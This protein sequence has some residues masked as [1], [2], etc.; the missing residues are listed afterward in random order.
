MPRTVPSKVPFVGDLLNSANQMFAVLTETWLAGHKQAEINIEG[1]TAFRQDR[2]CQRT[3]K[4]GRDGGGALIY[5]REDL[6]STADYILEFSNGVVDVV[7]IHVKAENLVIFAVYRQPDGGNGGHR[8]RPA[9]LQQ[10]IGAIGEV[11]GNLPG[12]TPDVVLAGDFNLP[13]MNWRDGTIRVG[14]SKDEQSMIKCLTEFTTEHFLFQTINKA[15]HRQGNVLDL[16]F[17]NNPA[18]VHSFQC[19]KTTMSDHLIIEVKSS[20]QSAQPTEPAT[21]PEK[22]PPHSA[23]SKFEKLNFFSDE[24]NWNDLEKNLQEVPWETELSNLPPIKMFE[25]FIDICATSSQ[26]FCPEKKSAKSGSKNKIPRYRRNLMRRRGKVNKQLAASPSENKR[27]KLLLENREIELKLQESYKNERS[28]AE[29]HAV[30]SIKKNSKY[31]YSYAKKYSKVFTGIGPLFDAANNI[32]SCANKMSEM[33]S[34]QYRSVFSTP[35]EPLKEPAEIFSDNNP[36]I[37][38]EMLLDIEFNEEDVAEAIRE[39]SPTAAA[40][41]DRFPAILLKQCCETLSK[42]L[43]MMWRKSVD[44]GQIPQIL[45]TAHIIP[46]HKGESR[47]IPK[48]YRPIAL[49]SHLIKIFEKVLRKKIVEY[50]EKY[51]LFNPSQHGFRGGRSCL[52]QL[53]IHYDRILELLENGGS[54]D[55]VYIDFAKAFDKLDFGITL[56]KLSSLG[57]NGKVGQWIHCFLTKR[58]QL[59]LVNG[60]RSQPSEVISGVPQGSVLG[61]LLFLILLGDIDEGITNAFLSSFADDTRI[62]N[63]TNTPLEVANFQEDLDSVYK[64][65]AEN[66]MQLNNG[67]FEHLHYGPPQNDRQFKSS[68]DSII[69]EKDCVKDLGVLMSNTGQFTQHIHKMINA[70]KQQCS[71]ILRTFK[72]REPTLMLTLWKSLVQSRIEYCSQLW[73]PLK[74]G[75]IQDIEMVQRSFIRK[76]SGYRS[77]SYWEQLKHLQLYSLE[78]RRERYRIIYIWRILEG[79]VPNI[80]S[81]EGMQPKI[82]AKCHERRGRECEIPQVNRNAPAKVQ[83]LIYASLP[84]HGQRLFNTLPIELRNIHNCT[85]EVFK[86]RLDDY[87]KTIPDEPQIQGYTSQRRA[88]SNS[89]L[90][91]TRLVYAYHSYVIEVPGDETVTYGNDGVINDVAAA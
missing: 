57:I 75:A 60:A 21:Q 69:E 20:Y 65:T 89:L 85:V 68:S 74:K 46:I 73:C 47:G 42:P 40:G 53:I 41:P 12:P 22:D 39:I 82:R 16:C 50:M 36:E 54:V 5:L 86:K 23:A 27:E 14:A 52:S 61:P 26:K 34:E 79:Q 7:G 8:S 30:K 77:L 19:Q 51:S 15:T 10:A 45:K 4:R 84:I 62:L 56:K 64:W 67:K 35:K 91:M 3:T 90:D 31:F 55:V 87:L 70:A 72:T 2:K 1:Y 9:H 25:K 24:V 13:H 17:T 32:I 76:I 49:T 37:D 66:N 88:E 38:R 44:E 29:H 83:S 48:N 18:F 43:Y 6:A 80:I 63:Q 59:V 81:A 33:F 78:R 11:I 28:A 58:K 71:W